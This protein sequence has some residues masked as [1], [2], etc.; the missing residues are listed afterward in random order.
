MVIGDGD[1]GRNFANR[2]FVLMEAELR[3][4]FG[5]GDEGQGRRACNSAVREIGRHIEGEM[6]DIDLAVGSVLAIEIRIPFGD[7][8]SPAGAFEFG[9]RGRGGRERADERDQ[10]ENREHRSP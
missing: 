10:N 8:Q 6:K 2:E 1:G 5:E 7:G 4:G 3:E 9:F